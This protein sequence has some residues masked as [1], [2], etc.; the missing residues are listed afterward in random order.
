MSTNKT[1]YLLP[2]ALA[3]CM[4]VGLMLGS[5]LTPGRES[6]TSTSGG[7]KYRKMQ[8][9]INILDKK[10]VDTINGENLFEETIADMLHK[11]DPH[12]NYIPARDLQ[13]MTESI[14]GQFGGIGVRFFIIRDTICITNV[15]VGSPSESVGIKAGDKII[16]VNGKK[17]A[18]KK[19]T[20][21]KVMSQLK[22]KPQTAVSLR[23]LRNGKL[24]NKRIVRDFIPIYSVVAAYMIDKETGY[25]KIDE[26]SMSTADEFRK[27]ALWLKQKGMKKMLLDLR[28]NGGGVLTAA[29]DIADEFLK[30]NIPIVK[31]IGEHTGT[32]T[33][34]ATAG[35]ILHDTKVAVLINSYSASASEILAGAIQDNDRGIIIGR[36]SFGKGLVQED[37]KLMDGSNL[38]LTVA[39]YYTPSGRC[40]Q[41]PYK[42]G[43]E[44]Y[45]SDQMDRYDN[46]ELYKPDTTLFADSLKFKTPKGKIVY[47]GGGI[48]PDVF[49]PFDSTGNSWYFS[50][51]RFS[52]AFQAFAFDYL[53]NKRSKWSNFKD[54]DKNFVV[55][56]AILNEFVLFAANEMKVKKDNSGLKHSKKLIER[57]LKSEIARQ[58]W[59]EEGYYQIVNSTDK[60]VQ[61][62][63]SELR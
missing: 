20:N 22:G 51:L 47:G 52:S 31:T 4:V 9:I 45:Y 30:A 28:N 21:E 40:I 26:F 1:R 55:N 50:E 44:D 10:Y 5:F 2:L 34:R 11:L 16:E 46:G 29:T 15:I 35:G 43:F 53:S 8:D 3:G 42:D 17:V 54:F 25:L 60:E 7:E 48:M 59:L 14:E 33:Y 63:L 6:L 24:L 61:R 19:I 37:V 32:Q 41:K 12:S 38:R 62:A 27:A 49:V 56:D 58:I 23:V 39:R 18:G 13:L 57:T 36:R